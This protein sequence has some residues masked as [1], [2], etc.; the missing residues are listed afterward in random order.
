MIKEAIEKIIELAPTMVRDIGQYVYSDRKLN[1]VEEPRIEPIML[2]SLTGLVNYLKSGEAQSINPDNQQVFIHVQNSQVVRVF[3]RLMK[4]RR[5]YM[6]DA[7]FEGAHDFKFGQ[8]MTPEEF[9]VNFKS[10]AVEPYG[11]EIS[12]Y[13]LL[14][15]LASSI[16]VEHLSTMKDSGIAQSVATKQG[17]QYEM[18]DLPPF[19]KLEFR[20]TFPEIMQYESEFFLRLRQVGDKGVNLAL[21]E[22][23]YDEWERGT[24]T[25]IARWLGENLMGYPESAILE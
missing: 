12:D 5:D 3:T 19:L 7:R 4:R 16:S 18:T 10:C 22:T 2:N 11:K 9:I 23:K 13:S 15:K 20:R 17:I 14:L 8:W 25:R 1:L 24:K 21:F 6:V